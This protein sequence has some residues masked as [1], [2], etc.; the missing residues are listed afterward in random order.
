VS[1]K[2]SVLVLGAPDKLVV[3]NRFELRERVLSALDCGVRAIVLDLSPTD[4][5]DSAGLGT[6]VLLTKRAR[7]AGGRMVLSGLNDRV[8]DLLRLTRLDQVLEQASTLDEG[9]RLAAL[10]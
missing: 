7:D 5:V 3:S 2:N 9:R 4:Y 6:L 10:A 1:G 8:A